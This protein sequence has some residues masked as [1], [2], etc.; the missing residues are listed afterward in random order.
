M[1]AVCNHF[2]VLDPLVVASQFPAAFVGKSELAN[3][4]AIG[5]VTRTFGVIFVD[6]SRRI[7]TS[8]FVEEVQSILRR[9][10]RVV[11]FP[12]GTTFT[13]PEVHPFKTGA[14]EAVAGLQDGYV[15]PLYLAVV[16]AD[17]NPASRA[18]RERVTWTD[19]S[20]TFVHNV[21]GLLRLGRVYMRVCVGEPIST[22]GL[23][24]KEL[25]ARAHAAVAELGRP[26][27]TAEGESATYL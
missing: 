15:L 23:D 13:G 26:Y 12:E 27:V 22:D 24:R 8:A 11:V 17:G 2:G 18:V 4:P 16:D 6:R 25:A 5:W 7:R 9:G 19:N 21:A 3:W 20:Q 10:I 1:L 14:F